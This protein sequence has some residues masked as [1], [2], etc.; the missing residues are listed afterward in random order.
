MRSTSLSASSLLSPVLSPTSSETNGT[1][2]TYPDHSA[3]VFVPPLLDDDVFSSITTDQVPS[4]IGSKSHT[5]VKKEKMWHHQDSGLESK[6]IMAICSY[7]A[8][9]LLIDMVHLS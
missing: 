4:I 1:T 2:E 3:N 8:L 5:Q 9:K 7:H 6:L